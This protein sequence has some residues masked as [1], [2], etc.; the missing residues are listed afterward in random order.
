VLDALAPRSA[1][2]RDELAQRF[3]Q[4]TGAGWP[5]AWRTR[6]YRW[7]P[8]HRAQRVGGAPDRFG[9]T[10]AEFHAA[11]EDRQRRWARA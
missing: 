10:P 9:V 11:Q 7:E 5:R 8:V 6:R 2:R 1:I 3:Q 4:L